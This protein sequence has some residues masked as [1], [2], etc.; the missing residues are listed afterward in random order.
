MVADEL[1]LD[2]SY[3]IALAASSDQLHSR[4]L[5]LADEIERQSRRLVTT[6]AVLLEIGNALSKQRYRDAAVDLLSSLESDP[7]V[8]VVPMT[9]DLY[10]QAFDLFRNRPDKEW[11]LTDCASFVVMRA[12][13][14]TDALTSDDHF[15]QAGFQALLRRG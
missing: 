8:E 15:E 6:R 1:F 4:A 13:G 2:A 9:S 10:G 3:A 5:E 12:R 14:M 11:G 7:M